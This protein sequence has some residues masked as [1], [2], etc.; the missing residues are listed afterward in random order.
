LPSEAKRELERDPEQLA[1][2]VIEARAYAEC[3]AAYDETTDPKDDR[4]NPWR[5]SPTLELVSD[6]TRELYDER[7]PKT[8]F[9]KQQS[10]IILTDG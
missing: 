8:G 4:L 9:K 7:R 1:I 10:P 3:K 2:H 5:D 6:I